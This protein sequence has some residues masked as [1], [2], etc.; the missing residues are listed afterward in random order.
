MRDI[1]SIIKS[2]STVQVPSAGV[3]TLA[4]G[5]YY[6]ELEQRGIEKGAHVSTQ[7]VWDGNLVAT[8]DVEISNFR[9]ATSYGA[10]LWQSTNVAQISVN[11][12]A[13]GVVSDLLNLAAARVR[14]KIVVATQ[15]TLQ[16]AENA[17]AVAP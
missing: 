15:G 13:G 2:D 10:T 7:W 1:N 6:A 16:G 17:K 11:A 3:Y 14:W 12:S 4:A 9:D 5:T 8:L